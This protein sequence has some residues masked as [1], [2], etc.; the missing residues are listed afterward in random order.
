MYVCRTV[1]TDTRTFMDDM[2]EYIKSNA[3]M[4]NAN[5]V[6]TFFEFL[7]SQ[8]YDTDSIGMDLKTEANGLFDGNINQARFGNIVPKLVIEFMKSLQSMFCQ[9]F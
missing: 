7:N 6:E 2:I 4:T 1:A 8:K 3:S 9:S 5:D